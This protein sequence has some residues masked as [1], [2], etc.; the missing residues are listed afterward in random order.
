LPRSHTSHEGEDQID[1]FVRLYSRRM[2]LKDLAHQLRD[3]FGGTPKVSRY[4]DDDG[5]EWVDIL[6]SDDR[7]SRG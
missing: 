2:D 3:L 1:M 7:P 4:W 6:S 5:V